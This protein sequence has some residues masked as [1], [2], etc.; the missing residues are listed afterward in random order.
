MW[1][2]APSWALSHHGTEMPDRKEENIAEGTDGGGPGLLQHRDPRKAP[3]P[4]QGTGHHVAVLS[5]AC[6]PPLGSGIASEIRTRASEVQVREVPKV[7]VKEFTDALTL[8]QAEVVIL[9]LWW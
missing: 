2:Q 3:E 4:R 7:T 1:A 6:V 8:L 9:C 5:P